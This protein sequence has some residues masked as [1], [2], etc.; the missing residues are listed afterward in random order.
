M[1]DR[2]AGLVSDVL[3]WWR[4]LSG[5]QRFFGLCLLLAPCLLLVSRDGRNLALLLAGLPGLWFGFRIGFLRFADN[6]A[7]R[8]LWLVWAFL[9]VGLL[10]WALDGFGME[11]LGRLDRHNRLLFFLPW[12]ISLLWLQPPVRLLWAALAVG[13]LVTG[14][15]AGL[16]VWQSGQGL[17][18]RVSGDAHVMS[19]GLVSCLMA[20]CLAGG[21]WRYRS[22]WLALLLG[23]GAAA[24]LLAMLMT[25]VRAG[26]VGVAA[27]FLTLAILLLRYG[28]RRGGAVFLLGPMAVLAVALLV[29]QDGIGARFGE[30][31]HQ[32]RAYF[33]LE[34]RLPPRAESRTGCQDDARILAVLLDGPRF[35]QQGLDEARVVEAEAGKPCGEGARIHLRAADEAPAEARLPRSLSERREDQ[36]AR[37]QVRGEG[38][39]IR[40]RGGEWQ[41]VPAESGELLLD[42]GRFATSNLQIEL[43]PGGWI[44]VTPIARWKGEYRYTHVYRSMGRRMEMWRLAWQAFLERPLLGHGT[45]TFG[46]YLIA[47]AEAGLGDHRITPYSHAH[48]EYF[49][50]LA[51]RGILGFLALLLLLGGLLY[52]S[53]RPGPGQP[54]RGGHDGLPFA[55]AW[56]ALCGTF[57]TEAGLSMNLVAVSV[58]LLMAMA[59]YL[60]GHGRQPTDWCFNRLRVGRSRKRSA[61]D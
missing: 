37:V 34:A 27:G 30:G 12:L 49:E 31:V 23:L 28:D 48:S 51:T 25:G 24:A 29:A 7:R 16:E 26:V 2:Q 57:L 33:S 43:A 38:A 4:G 5:A 54:K 58:A 8:W 45:G 36:A 11:G 39:R 47:Q 13:G 9:M 53:L 32:V 40:A 18:H 14:V 61:A 50:A 56:M 20:V 55:A 59:L 17:D 1:T 10:A 41:S 19:F 46:N 15:A 42:A 3:A 35:H 21:A 52:V 22:E 60:G 6:G 44:D